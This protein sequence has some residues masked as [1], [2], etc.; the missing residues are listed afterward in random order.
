MD[1]MKE[2]IKNKKIVMVIGLIPIVLLVLILV[3][4]IT[5]SAN[6]GGTN[7]NNINSEQVVEGIKI[8][9]G[10][11]IQDKGIYN[12]TA[13]VTNTTEAT[14]KVDY[15]S[16]T[17]YDKDNKKLITLYGYVGR[18]VKTNEEVPISASVDKDITGATRVEIEVK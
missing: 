15:V 14:K 1:K 6:D 8:S 7:V 3:V 17:F 16:L 12:Y 9:E 11:I 10:L 2:M 5:N 4:N 13:K 18:D